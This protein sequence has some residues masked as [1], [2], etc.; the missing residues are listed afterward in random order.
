MKQPTPTLRESTLPLGLRQTLAG[1]IVAFTAIRVLG[2]INDP[3]TFW[4]IASGAHLAQTWDFVLPD[5]FGAAAEKQWILNQWLPQLLM[6]WADQTF[7]PAGV[8]WLLSLATAVLLLVLWVACRR[9]ASALVTAMVMAAAV[10]TMSASLSPRPQLVTFILTVVVTDAWL[11]TALDHRPRWWLVPLSWV[12]ACSHGM[13]FLGAA[14]GLA[15]VVGL[16]MG[17]RTS[18]GTLWRLALIPALSVV[19]AALTPVGP[20]LLT[21]PFQVA[22]VAGLITEWQPA[23]TTDPAF[24]GAALLLVLTVVWL[25]RYRRERRWHLVLLLAMV[26]VLALTSLRTVAIAGALIAPIAAQALQQLTGLPRE[27]VEARE[28]VTTVGLA[29]VGLVLAA[30]IA[31]AQAGATTTGREAL[32]G[33]LDALPAGTVVCNDQRDGGWLIWRHPQLRVTIDTRVE[34]YS[35]D[36]I[37]QYLAFVDARPGWER[38]PARVRCTYALLAPDAAVVE[39]LTTRMHWSVVESAGD[40]VLLRAPA[41]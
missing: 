30:L 3:D 13:W 4:H 5:P 32:R 25:A 15:V 35:V 41:S 8:S 37:R 18:R 34:I 22:G 11:R 26:A 17:H 10:L 20:Q 9:R 28:K 39:A 23:R 29:V 12:W 14:V 36:H 19:V 33:P 1:L 27:P 21:S 40:R 24:V 16:A 6:H 31:P 2:P 38:Y 7:G